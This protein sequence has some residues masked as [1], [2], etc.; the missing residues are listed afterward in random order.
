MKGL[1][2]NYSR[3]RLDAHLGILSGP[4]I[5]RIGHNIIAAYHGRNF[6]RNDCNKYLKENVF[7]DIPSQ[8]VDCV[9]EFTPNGEIMEVAYEIKDKIN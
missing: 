2:S 9:R 6:V 1:I 4:I 5:A 7:T 8:A 3:K